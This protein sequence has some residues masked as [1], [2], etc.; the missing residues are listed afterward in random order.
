MYEQIKH[1]QKPAGG[2][3]GRVFGSRFFAEPRYVKETEGS[4]IVTIYRTGKDTVLLMKELGIDVPQ[5]RIIDGTTMLLY[6]EQVKALEENAPY[7]ISMSLPDF[8]QIK[9]EKSSSIPKQI[10]IPK[11]GN[12]PV[13]G[14]IDGPF[15]ESAYCHDWVSYE[16]GLER[17]KSK[18]KQPSIM[19]QKLLR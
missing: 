15:D 12:E 19:G 5:E 13:V 18:I 16:N 10:S 3:V 6:P 14:V 8:S 2:D 17:M 9:F 7:L 11:P 1:Y 4:Q